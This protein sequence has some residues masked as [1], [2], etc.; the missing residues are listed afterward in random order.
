MAPESD[1]VLFNFLASIMLA[2]EPGRHPTTARP[3]LVC[4][5]VAVLGLHFALA[6]FPQRS[7]VGT[8]ISVRSRTTPLFRNAVAK[9]RELLLKFCPLF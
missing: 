4:L 1:Q 6:K 9:G 5:G 2:L 7:A 8:T 3:R